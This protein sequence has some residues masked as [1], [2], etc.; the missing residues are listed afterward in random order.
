MTSNT[1]SRVR[2]AMKATQVAMPE[3]FNSTLAQ[4][5]AGGQGSQFPQCKTVEDLHAEMAGTSW[6]IMEDQTNVASGAVAVIGY[7]YGKIGCQDIAAWAAANPQGWVCID[8]VKGTGKLSVV[9]VEY[10]AVSS[11]P[12]GTAVAIIGQHNG[13]EVLFTIHPGAPVVPSTVT[14]EATGLSHGHVITGAQ[15]IEFGFTSVKLKLV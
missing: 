13:Q 1:T 11:A 9:A 3:Y 7:F 6:R 4:R 15:A 10:T 12:T 5:L 14:T 2:A 8:D